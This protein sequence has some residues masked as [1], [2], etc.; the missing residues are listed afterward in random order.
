MRKVFSIICIGF[1]L[2]GCTKDDD[3]LDC[4]TVLPPPNWFE[5]S[6]NDPGGNQL[7]NNIFVQDS[8]LFYS[9]STQTYLKPLEFAGHPSYLMIDFPRI[10]NGTEYY[11]ELSDMDTDTLVFNFTEKITPC[12]TDYN[13]AEILYNGESTVINGEGSRYY[14]TKF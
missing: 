1:I 14:L 8:F 6:I 11:L 12:Y 4:T 7:I 9:A 5:I 3:A 2:F 13:L 10:S